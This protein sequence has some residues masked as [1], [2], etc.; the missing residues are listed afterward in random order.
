MHVGKMGES[1]R[2]KIQE[3]VVDALN[4]ELKKKNKSTA[5]TFVHSF[6][7]VLEWSKSIDGAVSDKIMWQFLCGVFDD[8]EIIKSLFR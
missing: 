8:E 4:E 5:G 6:D 2:R 1:S 7:D 3:V